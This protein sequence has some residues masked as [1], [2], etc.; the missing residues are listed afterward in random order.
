MYFGASVGM[1]WTINTLSLSV[2][3]H[4]NQGFELCF[5]LAVLIWWLYCT[6]VYL[7]RHK[8]YV[9]PGL[10]DCSQHRRLRASRTQQCSLSL[11]KRPL[12]VTDCS[13]N[14]SC[15]LFTSSRCPQ[16]WTQ[17]G[18]CSLSVRIWD[19]LQ[20]HCVGSLMSWNKLWVSLKRRPETWRRRRW[21][22]ASATHSRSQPVG[23]AD[24]AL[25]PQ[26]SWSK[27]INHCNPSPTSCFWSLNC[28]ITEQA[29]WLSSQKE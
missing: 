15:L 16:W 22:V 6:T 10:H 1:K 19:P 20:G 28:S 29:G 3:G 4:Q 24:L 18:Q 8:I 27:D 2:W 25:S 26:L 23:A 12:D 13:C 5:Y 17:M 7:Q 21:G 11:H 14:F 9:R